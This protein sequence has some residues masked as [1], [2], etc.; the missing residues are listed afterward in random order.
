MSCPRLTDIQ[1]LLVV[2]YTNVKLQTK[3]SKDIVSPVKVVERYQWVTGTHQS[4]LMCASGSESGLLLVCKIYYHRFAVQP[5]HHRAGL[6]SNTNTL[7]TPSKNSRPWGICWPGCPQLVSRSYP[8]E[9]GSTKLNTVRDGCWRSCQPESLALNGMQKFATT[10]HWQ[11]LSKDEF[12]VLMPSFCV[13][14]TCKFQTHTAVC[15]LHISIRF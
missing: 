5:I 1:Y 11:A 3:F 4:R 7:A 2:C 12:H 8:N 15:H 14:N 6:A 9:V 10:L 13:D